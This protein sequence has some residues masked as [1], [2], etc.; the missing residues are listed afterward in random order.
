MIQG[1]FR[2]GQPF[3]NAEKAYHPWPAFPN[4]SNNNLYLIRE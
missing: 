2:M 1:L 4:V 3:F